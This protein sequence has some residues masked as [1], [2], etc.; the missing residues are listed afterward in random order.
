V[1]R[2]AQL[3]QRVRLG[4]LAQQ[5]DPA[6][7][8]IFEP[9]PPSPVGPGAVSDPVDAF[10][11]TP[12]DPLGLRSIPPAISSLN[13]FVP[14][15]SV[16]DVLSN[17]VTGNA[18]AAQKQAM[19]QQVT[20]QYVQSGMD[21]ATAQAQAQQDVT[22]ALKTFTGPGA[23]GVTWTG[24]D[25]TSPT[26]AQAAGSQALQSISGWCSDDSL[27]LG[28]NN[29]EYVAIGVGLFVLYLAFKG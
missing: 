7:G 17:A 29:C 27:G 11:A 6:T 28:L 13:P 22:T 2:R 16:T 3:I 14:G 10:W 19:V 1:G 26:F 5:S 24:A 9:A 18:T 4:Y 23:F 15:S 21:P 25:P 12:I 20:A 8:M